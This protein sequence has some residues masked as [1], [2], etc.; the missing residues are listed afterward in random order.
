MTNN[1]NDKPIR[2][3]VFFD[4]AYCAPNID[5]ETIKK[6][7]KIAEWI[8]R[9]PELRESLELLDPTSRALALEE[10]IAAIERFVDPAYLAAIRTGE[11]HDVAA[12][13]GLGWDL[14]LYDMV[15]HS[16]AGILSALHAVQKGEFAAASLSSGL[17]HASPS[18]GSGYCTVNSL[19]IAALVAASR[20][21]RVVILDLDAHCGGGTNAYLRKFSD[22]S[23]CITHIDVS[24]NPFDRYNPQET[25]SWLELTDEDGYLQAVERAL[26]QVEAADPD[27]V[28]YN[29]GVDIWP[30]VS[31]EIVRQ[32]D[33]IVAAAIHRLGARCVIVLAGGYGNDEEIVPMHLNT[34]TAFADAR[35]SG[36]DPSYWRP[37][38][39]GGRCTNCGGRIIPIIYGYPGGDMMDRYSRG[40]ISLGGCVISIGQPRSECRSCGMSP[41][42]FLYRDVD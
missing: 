42:S 24:V 34:L 41:R 32:R 39:P 9:T 3:P 28:F 16:T 5:F 40:E 38:L 25:G 18:R 10:A 26:A 7:A 30:T 21:L 6:A 11:P 22:L 31:P 4:D 29:A 33:Q 36:G 14:A 13:N 15:V 19:A 20:K 12:S 37:S 27:V 1:P 2:M 35:Q 8:T 23:W 17:H